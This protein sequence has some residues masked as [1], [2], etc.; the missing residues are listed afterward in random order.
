MFAAAAA[1]HGHG[2]AGTATHRRSRS[3]PRCTRRC[4]RPRPHQ[5]DRH[6]V[7]ARDGMPGEAADRG[8]DRGEVRFGKSDSPELG[9]RIGGCHGL[10]TWHKRCPSDTPPQEARCGVTAGPQRFGAPDRALL[11]TDSPP[12]G[13]SAADRTAYPACGSA[14]SFQTQLD[15]APRCGR[16]APLTVTRLGRH[17]GDVGRMRWTEPKSSPGRTARSRRSTCLRPRPGSAGDRV[18][19]SS[20]QAWGHY[21]K[22]RSQGASARHRSM[23]S[24]SGS[25]RV[26]S[27]LLFAL[28]GQWR[29]PAGDGDH[30]NH[31]G[32]VP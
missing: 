30:V 27:R 9:E 28:V 21:R 16:T 12:P 7:S 31:A 10:R 19:S 2:P 5:S 29:L 3:V 11:D 32:S 8:Q 4:A 24:W 13:A 25:L 18:S 22:R 17:Q 20:R 1:R 14:T 23:R 26:G 15:D 6:V